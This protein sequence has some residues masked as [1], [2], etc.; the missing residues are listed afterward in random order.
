MTYLASNMG[1]NSLNYYWFGKMI[2]TVMKR[3]RETAPSAEAEKAKEGEK[4]KLEALGEDIVLDAAAELEE[5]GSLF[6][7]GGLVD[8]DE[9]TT[10]AQPSDRPTSARRRRG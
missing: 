1:L 5:D 2:S 3:F 4:T 6:I 9:K 7:N 8:S 10:S